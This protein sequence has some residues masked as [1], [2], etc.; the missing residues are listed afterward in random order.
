MASIECDR[1]WLDEFRRGER[2]ALARVFDTYVNDVTRTL[3]AGVVVKTADGPVRV[4]ANLPEADLE[5]LVHDTFVKVFNE[6]ARM[7]YDG[8][9]P[10]GAWV[11]TI[12]R[13]VLIDHGRASMGRHF[14]DAEIDDVADSGPS[15]EDVVRRS[16]LR[17]LLDRFLGALDGL[18]RRVFALRFVESKSRRDAGIALG[19]SEMQVRRRDVRLKRDLAQLL[20]AHGAAPMTH[21]DDD[22]G[23][24]T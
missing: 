14:V 18:D 4:G 10:F 19:M 2:A 13:H 24:S 17:T 11:A 23:D 6:R 16:E 22:D 3:R 7:S 12:A 21:L 5:G 9:R 15:Q 20:Y 8:L 1:A